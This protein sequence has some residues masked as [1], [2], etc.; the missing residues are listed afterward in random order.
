LRKINHENVNK[1]YEV[2][3][4][5]QFVYLVLDELNGGE[6]LDKIKS[7]SYTELQASQVFHSLLLGIKH[8]TGKEIIHRDLKP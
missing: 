4:D 2:F 7:Y 1:L 3:E 8:I 5:A 6:L